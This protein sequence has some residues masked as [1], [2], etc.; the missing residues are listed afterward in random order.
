MAVNRPITTPAVLQEHPDA[1]GLL[2]GQGLILA[3]QASSLS[4]PAS[5]YGLL[6]VKT[7]GLLYFKNDSGTE[8]LLS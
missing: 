6:Y 1:D 7:N 2:C 3:E 4:T 8:T 5:G